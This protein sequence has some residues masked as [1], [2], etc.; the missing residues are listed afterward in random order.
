MRGAYDLLTRWPALDVA[1]RRARLQGG[2]QR[3]PGSLHQVSIAQA[4][5]D[6]R[7]AAGLWRR[8]PSVWT[9]ERPVRHQTSRFFNEW[10]A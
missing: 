2:F 1:A 9:S 7:A 8:D 3:S 4:E 10:P 6:A 5:S